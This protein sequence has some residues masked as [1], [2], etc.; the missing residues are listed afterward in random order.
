MGAVSNE[1][2]RDVENP[3][4]TRP[5]A[6]ALD[7]AV[8]ESQIQQ[9]TKGLFFFIVLQTSISLVTLLTCGLLLSVVNLFFMGFA[10]Y[11]MAHRRIGFLAIH[12][13]YSVVLLILSLVVTINLI[14][15]QYDRWMLLFA[16]FLATQLQAVGIRIERR[17]ICLITLQKLS[18][19]TST[20]VSTPSVPAAST[21]VAAPEVAPAPAAPVSEST[22][23]PQTPV[24]GYGMP[25]PFPYAM[26][27]QGPVQIYY[28]FPPA[29][30]SGDINGTQMAMYPY[31]F[32]QYVP[33]QQMPVA[34]TE[35]KL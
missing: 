34:P 35:A 8:L 29:P 13:A 17:L 25:M 12:F 30:N 7:G 24:P 26:T 22:P 3:T 10:L 31:M 2:E 14:F 23:A 33:A 21:P 32:G 15:Y 11:G 4:T 1:P 19:T 16:C 5:A 20:S 9:A 18:S 28:S 27:P 6:P